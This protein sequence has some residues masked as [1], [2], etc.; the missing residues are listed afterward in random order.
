MRTR[1]PRK[2]RHKTVAWRNFTANFTR[3]PALKTTRARCTESQQRNAPS[4]PQKNLRDYH[5]RIRS[6]G[7][8]AGSSIGPPR[9][10]GERLESGRSADSDGTESRQLARVA[11]LATLKTW[12]R[13]DHH[14]GRRSGPSCVEEATRSGGWGC[15]K[16][17][18]IHSVLSPK[19]PGMLPTYENDFKKDK[20]T[21]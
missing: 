3:Q 19:L 12:D 1:G 21:R 7:R 10:P 5:V 16:A 11:L 8:S 15:D 18:L 17:L 13:K 6:V 20:G 4:K 2:G 14:L 9:P